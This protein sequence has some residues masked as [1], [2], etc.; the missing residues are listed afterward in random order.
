MLALSWILVIA[1]FN[2]MKFPTFMDSSLCECIGYTK[3]M[4]NEN[5]YRA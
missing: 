3:Q 4:C 5:N 2:I 1:I